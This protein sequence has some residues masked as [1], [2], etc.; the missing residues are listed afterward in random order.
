MTMQVMPYDKT[1][2]IAES[3]IIASFGDQKP[4]M[5]D[6]DTIILYESRQIANEA[7]CRSSEMLIVNTLLL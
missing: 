1:Q 2:Q 5:E 4:C 3:L 6:M 7:V